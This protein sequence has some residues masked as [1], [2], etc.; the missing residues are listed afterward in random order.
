MKTEPLGTIVQRIREDFKWL[1]D[2]LKEEN[3]NLS[4]NFKLIS[5]S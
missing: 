2:R 4:V 3:P 5:A 1:Y